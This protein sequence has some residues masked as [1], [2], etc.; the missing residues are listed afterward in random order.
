MIAIS[1]QQSPQIERQT[2]R[3][4]SRY[5][6][7]V[8]K[9]GAA[10][11]SFWGSGRVITIIGRSSSGSSRVKSCL[12]TTDL[13]DAPTLFSVFSLPA[14]PFLRLDHNTKQ[15]RCGKSEHKAPKTMKLLAEASPMSREKI[16]TILNSPIPFADAL[17]NPNEKEEC[18]VRILFYPY[19]Y[20]CPSRLGICEQYLLCCISSRLFLLTSIIFTASTASR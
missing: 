14:E 12:S 4:G 2:D 20:T 3:P 8:E 11:F 10:G 5:H 15:P 13:L 1:N 7:R 18:R 19:P 9:T 16:E 17:G 6:T